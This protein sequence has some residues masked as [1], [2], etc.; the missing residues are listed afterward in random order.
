MNISRT[1]LGG[2]AAAAMSLYPQASSAS[3]HD[4]SAVHAKHATSH[5]AVG[6]EVSPHHAM[7]QGKGLFSVAKHLEVGGVVAA[8]A[9]THKNPLFGLEALVGLVADVNT[10]VRVVLEGTA[11][12]EVKGG[13]EPAL[14]PAFKGALLGEYAFT[15]DVKGYAGPYIGKVGDQLQGGGTA[16]VII[17]L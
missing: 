3:E 7:V 2:A 16:G 1:I 17:D 12:F 10:K 14:E 5:A 15:Q 11:G 8:G 13:H 9:D 6:L 4:L